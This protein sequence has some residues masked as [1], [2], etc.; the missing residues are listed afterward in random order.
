M[1]ND[2]PGTD[3]LA[4]RLDDHHLP[5]TNGRMAVCRRCGGMTDVPGERHRP[6]PRQSDQLAAWLERQRQL[7][8]TLRQDRRVNT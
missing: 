6:V 7:V 3:D 8:G 5:E 4:A 2:D 1:S